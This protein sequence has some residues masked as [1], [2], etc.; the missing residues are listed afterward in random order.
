MIDHK[1]IST[2][3]SNK[4]ISYKTINFNTIDIN[5]LKVTTANDGSMFNS[6]DQILLFKDMPTFDIPSLGCAKPIYS[7]ALW[8]GGLDENNNDLHIAAQ[9]YR[10]AGSDYLPGPIDLVSGKYDSSANGFYNKIW[11]IDRKTI[12]IFKLNYNK[13]SYTI[14]LEILDWPAHGRGNFARNLAPFEDIDNNGIYEPTKGDYP[15]IKGDQ[16]L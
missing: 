12:E 1:H 10:Q 8:V 4:S 3:E 2:L 13:P 11:K 16:M 5:E 6:M 14:P 9:T 7:A 15:K